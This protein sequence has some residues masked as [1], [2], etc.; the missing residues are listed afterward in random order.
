M[1]D[2]AQIVERISASSAFQNLS[3]PV[4]TALLLGSLVLVPAALVCL[5]PF[6]RIV[7]VLSFVRRAVTSQDIPPNSVLI[8]LSLF[9]TL[10]VMGPTLEGI[11][12]K[13]IG[14]YLD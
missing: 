2:A 3:P 5:S 12:A 11:N 7:I 4:Q 9:L 6:T 14:P 13:A 8:G 10:F 1:A